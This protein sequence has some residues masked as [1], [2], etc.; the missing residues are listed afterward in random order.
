MTE[1]LALLFADVEGSTE[2][3]RRSGR[4]AWA[5]VLEQYERIGRDTVQAAG[6]EVVETKGDEVFA[7]FP[8]VSAAAAG[9]A[10]LVLRSAQEEWATGEPPQVRVGI[11]CGPAEVH[12]GRYVGLA[13]HRARRVCASAHGGQILLSSS[14]AALLEDDLPEGLELLDLGDYRLKDF[15]RPERLSQLAVPGL[16]DAFSPPRA[17]KASKTGV[18][19]VLMLAADHLLRPRVLLIAGVVLILG[20]IPLVSLLLGR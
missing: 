1:T 12:G 15:P 4:G 8:R 17:P 18:S 19:D 6:G 9:A 2:L 13:V 16:R 20:V 14:A 3:L 7:V 11:H 10:G 5:S